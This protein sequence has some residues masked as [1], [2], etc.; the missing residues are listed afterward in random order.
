MPELVLDS[1]EFIARALE[2]IAA[3]MLVFGFIISTGRFLMRLFQE[4]AADAAL[5]Y[6]HS[7]GRTVIIGLE[8]FVAATIIKTITLD[9]TLEAMGLL[10][11][12]MVIRAFLGFTTE[13]EMRGCWPW[14]KKADR[15]ALS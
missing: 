10:I 6:R 8:M 15:K 5:N 14:E 7:L 3:C 12:M 4:S 2:I 1:L 9:R 11:L 13:I